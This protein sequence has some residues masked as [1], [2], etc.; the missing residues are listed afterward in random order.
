[1][2]A[3]FHFLRP[4]WLLSLIP[5]ALIWWALFRRQHARSA[6]Q[7]L[8][9]PHL[10]DHLLAGRR[11]QAH[12]WPV[13]LLLA[14]WLLMGIAL[15]GPAWEKMPS[16][17]AADMA[18][19]MV[20]LK[21]SPSMMAED[22]P[23]SRL[24][25]AKHKLSDLLERREGGTTGLIAY[26]GSAHLVM[27]LTRDGRIIETMA[28]GLAPDTMPVE[29]DALAA[30]LEMAATHIRNSGEDGAVVVM[31]DT[32]AAS[33]AAGGAQESG[34]FGR[35][36]FL[37]VKGPGAAA[38]P[39]MTS[40]AK[41]LG[42]PVVDLSVD[43]TDVVTLVRRAAG[44]PP[45]RVVSAEGTERWKDAGYGLLPLI[46]LISLLWARRGWTVRSGI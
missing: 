43:D 46:A 26:A 7:S 28:Q 12:L 5:A 2:I 10:L 27:P 36:Q 45:A 22:V 33:Q 31:A 19:M 9:A 38:D 20:V 24:E 32:V 1:M 35:V 30:A 17:F 40:T 34:N 39:G 16:P 25:R 29:G 37:A 8:I 3:N 14:V 4:Y 23:P 44:R 11:R 15:A 6:W 21:V 42:A 13:H 41:A 18:G